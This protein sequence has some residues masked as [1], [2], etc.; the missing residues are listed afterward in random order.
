VTYCFP[1]LLQTLRVLCQLADELPAGTGEIAERSRQGK[2]VS[3]S[4]AANRLRPLGR[5]RRWRARR[6]CQHGRRPV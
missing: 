2:V 3:A 4:R 6:R 1:R 5:A